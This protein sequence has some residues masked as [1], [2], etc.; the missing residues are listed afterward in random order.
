MAVCEC[1]FC[2]FLCDA[3]VLMLHFISLT[4]ICTLIMQGDLVMI[5][6]Y[7]LFLLPTFLRRKNASARIAF[8]M[9][10]PWPSSEIYRTLPYR[11]DDLFLHALSVYFHSYVLV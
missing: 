10:T 11:Y 7:H 6:D 8:F 2:V 5:N 9:H 1:A 3:V 4:H